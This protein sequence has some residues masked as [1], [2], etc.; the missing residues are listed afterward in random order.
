MRS[1]KNHSGN[2]ANNFGVFSGSEGQKDPGEDINVAAS[3]G[4]EFSSPKRQPRS[5]KATPE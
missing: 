5:I 3:I 2:E 1:S 4:E